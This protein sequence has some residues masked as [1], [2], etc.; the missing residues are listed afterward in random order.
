MNISPVWLL[1]LSNVQET[2]AQG[3][4]FPHTKCHILAFSS[5]FQFVAVTSKF[6]YN[7]SLHIWASSVI[8]VCILLFA[9]HKIC[10]I[11]YHGHSEKRQSPFSLPW[12]N[13]CRGQNG[14]FNLELFVKFIFQCGSLDNG[15]P[16]ISCLNLGI[17][18][19]K[20]RDFA[21]VIKLEI[22]S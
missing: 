4:I 20:A 3:P 7:F 1:S 16:N 13:V 15:P 22:L 11:P 12:G 8:S 17:L 5:S 21:D 19:H 18:L 9:F 2:P 14:D 10:W 6:F